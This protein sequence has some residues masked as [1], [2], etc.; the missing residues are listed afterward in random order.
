MRVLAKKKKKKSR[1][2][3]EK[4]C[5]LEWWLW[6][7]AAGQQPSEADK[8]IMRINSNYWPWLDAQF[9]TGRRL[10]FILTNSEIS[11]SLNFASVR[12]HSLI[13]VWVTE[14]LLSSRDKPFVFIM[15]F[16]L[17]LPWICRLT[18]VSFGWKVNCRSAS[19][20]PVWLRNS[21]CFEKCLHKQDLSE[22]G[23]RRVLL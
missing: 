3:A 14:L 6:G 23:C 8:E 15:L 20:F 9:C 22:D 1:W 12:P 4:A 2:C 21:V 5:P 7:A 11:P 18:A 17:W 19:C 13:P 10:V 16:A